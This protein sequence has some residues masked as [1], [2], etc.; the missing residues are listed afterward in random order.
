VWD[1]ERLQVLLLLRVPLALTQ[2]LLHQLA[3]T[4][5]TQLAASPWWGRNREK[6]AAT[7]VA[8][9][10]P[11]LLRGGAG[12]RLRKFPLWPR[13]AMLAER[14]QW[15]TLLAGRSA[16]D[17]NHHL[18]PSLQ[19]EV[20]LALGL[21]VSASVAVHLLLHHHWTHQ[22]SLQCP[23]RREMQVEWTLWVQLQLVKQSPTDFQLAW[24]ALWLEWLHPTWAPERW[25]AC[26]ARTSGRPTVEYARL[27]PGAS[28]GIAGAGAAA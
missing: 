3:S 11:V 2:A 5:S 26:R 28:R 8:A 15:E 13:V 18:M 27:P 17:T 9:V 25:V 12:Q 22:G 10:A 21:A 19:R 20:R 16:E 1:L 7:S 4:S 14:L 24:L 6:R 23:W